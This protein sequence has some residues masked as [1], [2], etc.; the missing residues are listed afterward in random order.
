MKKFISVLLAILMVVAVMPFAIFAADEAD[1]GYVRAKNTAHVCHPTVDGNLALDAVDMSTVTVA[2]TKAA[3]DVQV[4]EGFLT[5]GNKGTATRLPVGA[6][7]KLTLTFADVTD[8]GTLTLTVNGKGKVNPGEEFEAEVIKDST[9]NLKVKVVA[10]N[11]TTKVY[12]DTKEVDTSKLTDLVVNI[13]EKTTKIEITTVGATSATA[14]GP[15][16]WEVSATT[17]KGEDDYEHDYETVVVKAPT[18]YKDA[19]VDGTGKA[20]DVC[21]KCGDKTDEYVLPALTRDQLTGG[22]IGLDD[23]KEFK[24][25]ATLY[26]ADGTVKKDDDGNPYEVALV[27]GRNPEA[28]FNG[29]TNTGGGWTNSGDFYAANSSTKL[30]IYFKNEIEIS[31]FQYYAWANWASVNFEF[32]KGDTLV[33]A[34]N[35]GPEEHWGCWVINRASDTWYDVTNYTKTKVKPT[36]ANDYIT[37][38]D[39][40]GDPIAMSLV[41]VKFD[42]LTVNFVSAKGNCTKIGEIKIGTHEHVFAEAD[43]K[44]GTQGTGEDVCK[45]T[46]TSACLECHE[47]VTNAV[48]HLHSIKVNKVREVE[49][50]TSVYYDTCTVKDCKYNSGEYTV[51]GTGAHEFNTEV[52]Q[53]TLGTCGTE[54]KATFVCSVCKERQEASVENLVG[55]KLGADLVGVYGVVAKKNTVIDAELIEKAVM[56][57][58]VVFPVAAVDSTT[59]ASLIV[60]Y[61]LAVDFSSGDLS[62]KSVGAAPTGFHTLGYKSYVPSTYTT[63]GIDGGYCTVC[64][65]DMKDFQKVADFKSL[66]T[67]VRVSFN[68]FTLRTTEY[69]GIRATFTVN[70]KAAEVIEADGEHSVRI[71]VVATNEAGETSELQIYGAGAK[72]WIDNNYKTSVVVKDVE[73]DEVITFQLKISVKDKLGNE[74]VVIR[75]VDSTTLAAVKAA[76][77]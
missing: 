58:A 12:E 38:P 11:G 42:K 75:D 49:C 36:N 30:E 22:F 61:T 2:F 51:E 25:I 1:E 28:L 27:T 10:Y 5:D 64:N 34:V 39:P 20:Y 56:T 57:G 19:T 16:L 23:V 77:K 52:V 54:G 43:V 33:A 60:N 70:K 59:K 62:V 14:G 13:F 63:H 65:A 48:T 53:N 73:A 18:L 66:D 6:T 50:G 74:Q 40:E 15:R 4:I 67:V 37:D 29:I 45:W 71:W 76:G 9:Y 32:Y 3:T 46:H 8:L 47:V 55:K 17:V 72:N 68:G 7:A 69:E 21:K 41:G 26:N 31:S 35:G 24:E 44:K